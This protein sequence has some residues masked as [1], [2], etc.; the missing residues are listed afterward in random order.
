M[1]HTILASAANVPDRDA[2]PH[3]LRGKES[4]VW[5]DQGYQG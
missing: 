3:L 2:P 4:P 5:G 1:I